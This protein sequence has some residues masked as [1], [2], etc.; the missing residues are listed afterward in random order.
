MR[1]RICMLGMALI[2]WGGSE[3]GLLPLSAAESIQVVTRGKPERPDRDRPDHHRKVY[4]KKKN[5]HIKKIPPHYTKVYHGKKCYYYHD[6]FYY[7]P[8]SG[9]YY[10]R[11]RPFIGMIV[12]VLP[13]RVHVVHRH[14]QEYLVCEGILYKRIYTRNGFRY[15]IV[16]FV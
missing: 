7:R 15:K 11:F 1:I 4:K 12:P 16:G 13:R 3:G 2:F 14:G 8:C 9:G 5:H 6:G 10:E